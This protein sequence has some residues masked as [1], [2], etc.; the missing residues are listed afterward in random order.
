MVMNVHVNSAWTIFTVGR[1]YLRLVISYANGASYA[2]DN[3]RVCL[4]VA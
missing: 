4:G 3:R 1:V 2:A